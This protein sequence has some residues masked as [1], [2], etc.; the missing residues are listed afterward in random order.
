MTCARQDFPPSGSITR[1]TL[2]MLSAVALG[3][4]TMCDDFIYSG[5]Y[6]FP[7][8]RYVNIKNR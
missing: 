4:P 6:L 7:S 1:T 3:I 5:A 8:P 2:M